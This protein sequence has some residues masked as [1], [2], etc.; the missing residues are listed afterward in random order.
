MLGQVV[1]GFFW[2]IFH[3]KMQLKLAPEHREGN[4]SVFGC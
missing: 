2:D 4:E 3:C 1:L